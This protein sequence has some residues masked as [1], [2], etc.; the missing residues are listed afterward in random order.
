MMQQ[1]KELKRILKQISATAW[2]GKKVRVRTQIS[3]IGPRLYEYGRAVAFTDPL[4]DE[5]KAIIMASNPYAKIIADRL[6]CLIKY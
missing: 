3:R 5:Q 6:G 1:A 2:G 4:T